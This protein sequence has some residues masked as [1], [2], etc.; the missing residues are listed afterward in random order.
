[1]LIRSTLCSA[2]WYFFPVKLSMLRKGLSFVEK[3]TSRTKSIFNTLTGL[4][5]TCSWFPC[6]TRL[7]GIAAFCDKT[8]SDFSS[9]GFD[10]K[11]FVKLCQACS[12]ENFCGFSAFQLYCLEYIYWYSQESW[13]P[14]LH[15]FGRDEA[16]NVWNRGK[17]WQQCNNWKPIGTYQVI[18]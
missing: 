4:K 6:I 18:N 13:R 5:I 17:R 7:V 3:G 16:W 9:Q 14:V 15:D 10:I 8:S 2:R 11:L 1:M 12:P